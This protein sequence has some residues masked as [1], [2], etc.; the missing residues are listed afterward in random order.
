ML[1]VYAVSAGY[2]Y[3]AV[4]L[5]L[6]GIFFSMDQQW[7]KRKSFAIHLGEDKAKVGNLDCRTYSGNSTAAK[8]KE[9][10]TR[11]LHSTIS[12]SPICPVILCVSLRACMREYPKK[13]WYILN[14]SL[15]KG[16]TLLIPSGYW[17]VYRILLRKKCTEIPNFHKGS[18]G[19]LSK[20]T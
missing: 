20:T 18:L 5:N 9:Y 16:S 19:K 7:W 2:T 10:W 6:D 3:R 13:T 15:E 8:K 4:L 1:T 11:I 14:I 12:C 17:L